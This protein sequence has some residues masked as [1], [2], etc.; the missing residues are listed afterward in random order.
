M[1]DI[2]RDTGVSLLFFAYFVNLTL[3]MKNGI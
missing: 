2:V 1:I 3:K